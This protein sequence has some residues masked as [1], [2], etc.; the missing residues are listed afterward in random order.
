[1]LRMLSWRLCAL[2]PSIV[3]LSFVV[4]LALHLIPGDPAVAYLSASQLPITEEAIERV[5][6]ELGLDRTVWE[7]YASWVSSAL[8]MDF[9][10]SYMTGEP[11]IE[12]FLFYFPAT[13]ELSVWAF[14]IVILSVIGLGSASAYY[15]KTWVDYSSRLFSIV[16][17]SLPSF[18]LGFLLLYVFSM[19]LGIFPSGN[20]GTVAHYVLPV[21]TLAI[22]YI[23]IYSRLFRTSLLEVEKLPWM[24]HARARGLSE[25]T[26]WLKFQ[27]RHG[28]LALLPV[29]GIVMGY[30]L[31]GTFIVE[32]IFSWPGVGRY[33]MNAIVQRDYPVI[34]FYIL[35][36]ACLFLLINL[37]VDLLQA[38]LDP[39]QRHQKGGVKHV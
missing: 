14:L 34:Q 28:V 4:F 18:W 24:S 10:T 23:A 26:I 6:I 11:V 12:E 25:K 27:L 37:I 3:L 29:L 16:G 21:L 32:N 19:S 1:M 31:A 15:R 39:R 7:Q 17:A 38:W 2:V 36:I 22:P 5:T 13:V 9:G 20:R 33:M 35:V 8:T 30:L